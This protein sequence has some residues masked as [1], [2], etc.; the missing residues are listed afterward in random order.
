[1]LRTLLTRL[2]HYSIMLRTLLTR[3]I[4]YSMYVMYITYV[5]LHVCGRSVSRSVSQLGEVTGTIIIIDD[6]IKVI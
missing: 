1:M 5:M 4:H 6:D 3:L 2:I